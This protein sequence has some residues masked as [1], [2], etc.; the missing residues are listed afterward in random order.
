MVK[1][2]RS[3]AQ[4]KKKLE[5]GKLQLDDELTFLRVTVW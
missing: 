2:V 3:E 1:R 4:G 5:S